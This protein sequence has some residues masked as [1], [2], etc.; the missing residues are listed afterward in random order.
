MM[1]HLSHLL[2]PV[3]IV[4]TIGVASSASPEI[5][6]LGE[7]IGIVSVMAYFL[8][9]KTSECKQLKAENRKLIAR[10]A[11]RAR[12]EEAE[13]HKQPQTIDHDENSN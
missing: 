7:T 3:G 4:A 6:A 10:L 2:V 5:T 11:I 9:E 1:S 8:W 13:E 12:K